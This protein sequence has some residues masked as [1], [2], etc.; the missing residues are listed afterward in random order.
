MPIPAIRGR[1]GS[2]ERRATRVMEDPGWRYRSSLTVENHSLYSGTRTGEL[3]S[4]LLRHGKLEVTGHETN[5]ILIGTARL[6]AGRWFAS[7]QRQNAAPS[8]R[9]RGCPLE[10]VKKIQPR[11]GGV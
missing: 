11:L 1:M 4:G 6:K 10:S 7:E 3:P 2:L 5:L 8:P 9:R